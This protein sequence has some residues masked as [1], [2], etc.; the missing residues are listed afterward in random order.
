MLLDIQRR[1]TDNACAP[2]READPLPEWL[3]INAPANMPEQ[4]ESNIA[5]ALA[6]AVVSSLVFW[7]GLAVVLLGLL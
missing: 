3:A 6:I 4:G 2:R 1:Y 5:L 7:A